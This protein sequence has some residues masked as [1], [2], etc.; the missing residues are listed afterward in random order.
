MEITL[1]PDLEQ[2]IQDAIA[3]GRYQT[4][5][6][7]ICAGLRLLMQDKSERDKHPSTPA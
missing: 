7:V 2:F 5:S 6:E 1:T 4:A 3:T